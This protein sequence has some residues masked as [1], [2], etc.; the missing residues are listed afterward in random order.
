MKQTA[1]ETKRKLKLI[2][3][4]VDGGESISSSLS[5]V[6]LDFRRK[7]LAKLAGAQ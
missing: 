6:V 7:F 3:H 2:I 4:T 1:R 5:I